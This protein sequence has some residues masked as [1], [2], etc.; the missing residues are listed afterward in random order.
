MNKHQMG[1]SDAFVTLATGGPDVNTQA[2]TDA[3]KLLTSVSIVGHA[4]TEK[5]FQALCTAPVTNLTSMTQQ[6]FVPLCGIST[7]VILL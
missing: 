5:A 1:T 6:R 2:L 7:I 3:K 4:I